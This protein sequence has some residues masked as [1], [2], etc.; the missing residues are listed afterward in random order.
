MSREDR[1]LDLSVSQVIDVKLE[2][3][4]MTATDAMMEKM[5]SL[6]TGTRCLPFHL[7][8]AEL[9]LV[10]WDPLKTGGTMAS[11]PL[12]LGCSLFTN[13]SARFSTD[14]SLSLDVNETRSELT[15]R[16]LRESL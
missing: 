3:T 16:D 14:D 7:W 15:L 5:S 8:K 2:A 11:K 12:D 6:G 9:V 1:T 4:N 10:C 13:P